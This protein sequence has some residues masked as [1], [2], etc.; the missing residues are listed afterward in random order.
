[1]AMD[2]EESS[3]NVLPVTMADAVDEKKSTPPAQKQDLTGMAITGS[4]MIIFFLAYALLQERIMTQPWGPPPGEMFTY[5]AYLVLSNRIVA[6]VVA[7][8]VLMYNGDSLMNTAP[9]HK[10]FSISISNFCATYCQYEALKYVTFP[11]QTLAKCA[12]TLPVL[13]LGTVISGKNYTS[14]DYITCVMVTLGCTAFLLTG[15]ISEGKGA[16]NDSFYGLLLMA[17]YLSFDGFTSVFQ[18]KLFRGYKMSTYN[19]MLYVNLASSIFSFV[20]LIL[21]G[22]LVPAIQFS[23]EYPSFFAASIGLSLAATLGQLVIYYS[24]KNYGAL[25]FATV[26]TTRQV[27]TIILSCIVY[28]HPLTLAQWLSASVVFGSLYY[29]DVAKARSGAS[30]H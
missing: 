20:T 4:A 14:R 24:I 8:A 7:I 1:M 22:Q 18:E 27:F 12:K 21:S 10:Y 16:E 5:S 17:G 11:T 19:Q 28:F 2:K 3:P 29:K 13:F 23:V 25:F 9:L 6:M 26:M 30:R 15:E